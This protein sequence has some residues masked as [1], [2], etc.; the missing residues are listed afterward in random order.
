ML[1]KPGRAGNYWLRVRGFRRLLAARTVRFRP[2]SL[3]GAVLSP[4]TEVELAEPPPEVTI[5][6]IAALPEVGSGLHSYRMQLALSCIGEPASFLTQS[7]CAEVLPGQPARYLPRDE[8]RLLDDLGSGSDRPPTQAGTAALALEQD[9][10]V[11]PPGGLKVGRDVE[12]VKGGFL[13]QGDPNAEPL[14]DAYLQPTPLR[15]AYVSPFYADKYEYTVARMAKAV[16]TVAAPALA[17]SYTEMTRRYNCTWG[18]DILPSPQ[19]P[20]NCVSWETALAACQYSQGSLPTEAQWE[21]AA[22]GRG[23]GWAYAWGNSSPEPQRR[24]HCCKSG[25]SRVSWWPAVGEDILTQ[26]FPPDDRCYEFRVARVGAYDGVGC[27]EG[28]DISR[29][30]LFDLT[31]NVAEYV[32]DDF[33]PY[34]DRC[35]VTAGVSHDPLCHRVTAAPH[36]V[37]GG[38]YTSGAQGAHSAARKPGSINSDIGFRCVY[39]AL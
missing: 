14:V 24:S 11:P 37:R 28:G 27:P 1:A 15:A 13:I 3:C 38:S 30:Q 32:L 21:H 26:K 20:L 19:M 35:G 36:G 8:P 22:R 10:L 9:C 33:L 31:G 23:R 6:R 34:R 12:C 25:L 4:G 16:P 29:D 2:H 17:T 7:S 5:E 39:P 18:M